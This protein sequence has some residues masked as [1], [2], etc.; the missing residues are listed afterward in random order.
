LDGEKLEAAKAEFQQLEADGIVQRSTS[1]WASP[2]H[3]VQKKDG[4]WRLCGDFRRLNVV[5]ELDVYPL[6]NMMDFAAKAAG[7]TVFSKVDLRKGY[8]QIP[9][10]PADVPKTAITTPFGLFEY[11]R[12]PFGL[13]NAGASFQRHMD[14][15]QGF[16]RHVCFCGRCF[17]VQ[18]RPQGPSSAPPATFSSTS[19]KKPGDSR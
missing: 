18:C 6:P 16:G 15:A 10:N 9:V 11:K 13:R 2:L 7:C 17:G 3:M 4:T 5:T 14:H 8:N 12:L 1:P 19:T